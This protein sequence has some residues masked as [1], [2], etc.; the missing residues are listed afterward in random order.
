VFEH[1]LQ[2]LAVLTATLLMVLAPAAHAEGEQPLPP[3]V[4]T[5][6]PVAASPRQ[7][8]SGLCSASRISTDPSAD[9]QTS[10]SAFIAGLNSFMEN[11]PNASNPNARVTSVLRTLFDLSNNNQSGQKLSYGDY[12]NAVPGCPAGGCGFISNDPAISFGVRLRGFLN[13]T[14]D[15]LGMPVHFGFYTDD[16]VALTVYD[17]QSRAYPVINRPPKLGFPVW[18]TTNNVT[19]LKSGLYTLEVIY[20]A[21]GGDAAL[22]M[23]VLVGNFTDSERPQNQLPIVRLNEAGFSLLSPASL[24]Q[25][26]SGRPSYP[27]ENKCQQCNRQYANTA[28]NNGCDPSYYCN[29]AALCAPCDSA[30]FCGPSCSPCGAAT[31]L[32][33]NRNGT[34][35]CVECSED[36][37]CPFGRCDPVTNQCRGCNTDA[38]C[39][40]GQHCDTTQHECRDCVTDAQCARGQACVNNT[41]Q[42]CSTQDSCAGT[43]CNCCPGGL[44]C[45]ASTPGAS[46]TCVECT[47]DGECSDGK[48]CDVTNGRCVEKL[49]ACNTSER[50]GDQCTKCPSDRPYCL[51]GQV[52]VACRS[53]LECGDG[54]FCLSGE[55]SSCTTDKR[56]G[57]RC[58]ACPSASPFCLTD[59][60]TAGSS[61]VGCRQDADCGPGGSCDPTTHICSATTCAVTCGEGSVCLGDACVQCFADAH[62]PCG[63]TCD[64]ALNTCT[65][66][67]ED[68]GDCLGTQFCSAA[69][70][71]CEPGRRKPGTEAAGGAPCCGVT[72]HGAPSALAL[73]MVAVLLAR[74]SRG[75]A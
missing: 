51:D 63:G 34:Y 70:Q 60:T 64:T 42:T 58:G 43:S 68:S 72:A 2:K 31:P 39:S 1:P 46:P 35:T 65:T 16:A 74:R 54:K 18:R 8:G 3:V 69:T 73:L 13:V 11:A 71:Q 19:F 17:R 59:G 47:N 40:N 50:C 32:C 21:V 52:C 14:P 9:F 53:D 5:G 22:E 45:A 75:A 10:T 20:A 61:C 12:E 27:D 28:G 29:G 55:C 62:C 30:V 4:V 44:K 56:C 37:Q 41:C 26:E 57:A 7:P 25:T 66:S 6:D 33:L 36:S 67:C 48:R 23:A 24:Y 38:Q 15:M 49:A